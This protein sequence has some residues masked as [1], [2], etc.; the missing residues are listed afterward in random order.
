[1]KFFPKMLD[2]LFTLLL[3]LSKNWSQDQNVGV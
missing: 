1:M 3:E 2:S